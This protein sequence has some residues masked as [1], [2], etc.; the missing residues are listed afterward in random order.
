MNKNIKA[1][2]FDMDGVLIDSEMEYIKLFESFLA[3]SKVD[4]QREK[5]Y[6]LAGSTREVEDRFLAKLLNVSVEEARRRKYAYYERFPLNY[7]KL[8]KD[9]VKEVLTYLKEQGFVI[10]LASSSPMSNIQEVIKQCEIQQFFSLLVSG[11]RFKE[12]KPNPEIYE[13]T[14]EHLGLNKSEIL[15]VEDSNY[16]VQAAKSAGLSVVA[17]LDPILQFDVDKA[18]YKIKYLKEL[19]KL[20]K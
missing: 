8:R 1:F 4:I 13:Y 16:G 11:E 7:L 5:L 19:I 20:V 12:S 3:E 18:D 6:F 2:I 9:Y 15:V 10:A 17:L 14:V